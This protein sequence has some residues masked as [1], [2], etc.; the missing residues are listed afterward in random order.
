MRKKG[1]YR[2]ADSSAGVIVHRRPHPES[3]SLYAISGS[4]R[5]PYLNEKFLKLLIMQT[6]TKI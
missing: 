2:K 5:I 4:H 3:R 1:L 6:N